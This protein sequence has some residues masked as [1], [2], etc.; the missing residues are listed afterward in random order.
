MTFTAPERKEGEPP[1]L[2]VVSNRLPV[3]IKKDAK[4]GEY[5]YKVSVVI[6]SAPR[7]SLGCTLRRMKFTDSLSTLLQCIVTSFHAQPRSYLYSA[8]RIFRQQLLG[9]T[10]RCRQEVSS[11][12][13]QDVK[14]PCNSPGSVGLVKT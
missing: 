5:T 3:T 4:T 7:S 1:R 6:P 2:I 9:P 13:F 12:R 10:H 11:L 14:R 8:V